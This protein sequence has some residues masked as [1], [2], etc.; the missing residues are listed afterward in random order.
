[1]LVARGGGCLQGCVALR[2]FGE[3]LYEI[4]SLV[5]AEDCEGRG[6]GTCLVEACVEKARQLDG[7]LVF[8]L[9]LRPNLFRRLGFTEVP[10]QT[11]HRDD[12]FREKIW[13]DCRQCPKFDAC[14][15]IALVKELKAKAFA[16]GASRSR[17]ARSSR[18]SRNARCAFLI[19]FIKSVYL[20]FGLCRERL[21]FAGVTARM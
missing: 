7:N 14:N 5:V 4:R 12:K 21:I 6:I 19:F 9:T 8:T 3:G 2:G 10:I 15:E 1:F 20:I 17:G 18:E 13:A 11:F 16:R